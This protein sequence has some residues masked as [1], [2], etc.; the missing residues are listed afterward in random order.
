MLV[1][2]IGGQWKSQITGM[3]SNKTAYTHTHTYTH[4]KT[5][6]PSNHYS[7]PLVV[8]RRVAQIIFFDTEGIVG[9]SYEEQDSKVGCCLWWW[10]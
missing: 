4:T 8:G 5:H 1:L 10:L 2:L 3:V 7:I 9:D 6:F